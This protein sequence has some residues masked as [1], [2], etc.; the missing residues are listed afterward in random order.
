MVKILGAALI[1]FGTCA[2]GFGRVKKLSS[3][4]RTL[5]GVLRSL[6]RMKNEIC[7]GFV[8]M[9]NVMERMSENA[10]EP[11]H[12]F[13]AEVSKK[14]EG[15]RRESFELIWCSC[16]ENAHGLKLEHD[17]LAAISSLG[18]VLGKYDRRAQRSYI[19]KACAE[20]SRFRDRAE[21][22]REV[23][24]RVHAYLGIAAGLFSVVVLA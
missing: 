17:E 8:P 1:L 24:T 22:N 5:D 12:L 19:E 3:H 21:H 16:L 20:L 6:E 13:F 11:M 18:S 10:D 4:V 2:W 9:K 14:M 15:L 7:V 23:N